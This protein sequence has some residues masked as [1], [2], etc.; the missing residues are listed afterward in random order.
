MTFHGVVVESQLGEAATGAPQG[1]ATVKDNR[2]KPRLAVEPN[3]GFVLD[4]G[5]KLPHLS[6]QLF[7]LSYGQAFAAD[8]LD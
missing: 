8:S 1:T 7:G 5:I 6:S 4:S 2:L 3:L